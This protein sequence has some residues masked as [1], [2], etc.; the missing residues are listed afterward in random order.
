MNIQ[1]LLV[2]IFVPETKVIFE[3]DERNLNV[4]LKSILAPQNSNMHTHILIH[5]VT[6]NF[7]LVLLCAN[8]QRNNV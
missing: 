1:I 4:Q 6:E 7:L 3:N 8:H 5:I 2:Q